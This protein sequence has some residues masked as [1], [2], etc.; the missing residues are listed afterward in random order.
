[1]MCRL[2]PSFP[3]S[4]GLRPVSWPPRGLATLGGVNAGPAPVNLIV[5]AQLGQQSQMQTIPDALRL[6][7]PGVFASRSSRCQS[8]VLW[9]VFP[10]NAGGENEQNAIERGKIIDPWSPALLQNGRWHKQ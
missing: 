6:P 10:R 7:V 3:R 8:P 1:M 5:L 9:Q 4:V 2:L